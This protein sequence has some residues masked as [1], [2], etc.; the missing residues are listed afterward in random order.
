MSSYLIRQ[1]STGQEVD[2]AERRSAMS[3]E[4]IP[5]TSAVES[6]TDPEVVTDP[7]GST[8]AQALDPRPRDIHYELSDNDRA[9]APYRFQGTPNDLSSNLVVVH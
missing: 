6:E 8:I 5:S 9:F 4:E 1:S 3:Q 2:S 7:A